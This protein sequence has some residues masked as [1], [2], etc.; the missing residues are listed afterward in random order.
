MARDIRIC[1]RLDHYIVV[2]D[3]D[4]ENTTHIDEDTAENLYS[5]MKHEKILKMIMMFI[6]E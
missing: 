5:Y 2:I 1:K 3:E 6:Q 4:C